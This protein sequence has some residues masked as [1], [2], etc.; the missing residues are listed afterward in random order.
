M[1][2]TL[3]GVSRDMNAPTSDAIALGGPMSQTSRDD[4]LP[5]ERW[6]SAPSALPEIA[7]TIVRPVTIFTGMAAP[8]MTGGR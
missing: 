2:M 5:Y 4:T 1:R 6:R 8:P 3:S 7:C